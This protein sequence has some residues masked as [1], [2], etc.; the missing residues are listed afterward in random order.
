MDSSIFHSPISDFSSESSF[1]SPESLYSQSFNQYPLPFNENDSEEML[2]YGLISEATQETSKLALCNR[3]IKEEEVSSVTKENPKKETKSYR[4]VRRRPWGKFAA[5]IRD[6]TRH[7][8]RVWLGTFDSA[9]AAAL[10]YDQAAFS[11]RGA[12]AI[13]NFPVE[14]VRESLKDMKYS[15]EE[16]CSPV[17]ALKRKHSMRRKMVSRNKRENVVV[18]EDLG[19][20]YLEELLTSSEN[21]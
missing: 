18:L 21:C 11:M 14:R 10:A 4:G 13:L 7:G 1:G 2:L 9:E 17:V 19:A 3:I 8:I 6:S 12:G 15:Q 20:D 16:G 5:E